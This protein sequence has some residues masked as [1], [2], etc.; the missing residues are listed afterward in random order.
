M[1]RPARTSD[2]G[3]WRI[4]RFAELDSTNRHLLEAARAG[5]PD[6]LVAVADV[7]TEGRGRLD[8]SWEAPAGSSLLMSVLVRSP[9]DPGRVVM[10]AAVALARAVDDVAG[11]VAALKW[12][13][14]LMVGDRKLAGILAERAPD[15]AVVVGMGCNVR[16]DWFP[17]ELRDIA[18]AVPVE[19][20]ELLVAWLRA[21][22]ARLDALDA[23]VKDVSACSATLGRRVRVQLAGDDFEGT[24]TAL[25]D[26]GY[27][28]VDDRVITA[29]DVV[30]LRPWSA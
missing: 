6:G 25:T 3:R 1:P 12:P 8:R 17:D 7:Q 29:G 23:V 22:D 27:L 15:G 30:H 4:E 20:A 28:V 14:D 18:T 2:P 26:A 9:T 10:A 21:Y 16:A 19:R 5:A 11:V 13:N 24:A